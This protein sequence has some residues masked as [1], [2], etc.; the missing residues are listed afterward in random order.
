MEVSGKLHKV[1]AS[2]PGNNPG[3]PFIGG[4]VGSGT[5]L[6][7]WEKKNSLA[8]TSKRTP[9]CSAPSPVTT[10]TKL[11][12]LPVTVGLVLIGNVFN[13]HRDELC[14]STANRDLPCTSAIQL[15]DATE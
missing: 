9:G 7:C 1:F 13:R 5:C 6:G 12:Q 2:H 8:S 3:A 4:W 10:L 15:G 11:S 14:E